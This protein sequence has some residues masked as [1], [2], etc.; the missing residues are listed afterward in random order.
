MSRYRSLLTKINSHEQ[1]EKLLEDRGVKKIEYY[2]TPQ[3]DV[4]EEEMF[5]LMEVYSYTWKFGDLYSKLSSRFYGDP[6]YWWVIASFNKKPTEAHLSIGDV[7]KIPTN[8]ADALQ[9]VE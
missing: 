1:Y 4:V 8:L 9:V 3:R 5:N 7:I 6:Q 2:P